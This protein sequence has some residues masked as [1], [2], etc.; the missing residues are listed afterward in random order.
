[1][2]GEK[3]KKEETRPRYPPPQDPPGVLVGKH[4][5]IAYKRSPERKTQK[6]NPQ[7][8][9]EHDDRFYK[10]K[11]FW[12]IVDSQGEE[13]LVVPELAEEIAQWLDGRLVGGFDIRNGEVFLVTESDGQKSRFYMTLDKV[14]RS[15]I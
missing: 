5:A 10:E 7:P 12:V 8:S 15:V 2:T 4:L 14:T 11:G 1:M 6:Q 9:Q 13:L 3:P